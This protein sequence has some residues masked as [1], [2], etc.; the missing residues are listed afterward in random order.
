MVAEAML[1][2][3]H[4]VDKLDTYD[5]VRYIGSSSWTLMIMSAISDHKIPAVA[6]RYFNL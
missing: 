4:S 3:Y 1:E 5:Y 2:D 6:A